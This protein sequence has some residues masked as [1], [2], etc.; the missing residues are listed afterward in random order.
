M[1]LGIRYYVDRFWGFATAENGDDGSSSSSS[2]SRIMNK[3]ILLIR[4]YIV[5]DF[6]DYKGNI[7]CPRIW[8]TSVFYWGKNGNVFRPDL[9]NKFINMLTDISWNIYFLLYISML[10]NN[11]AA[12]SGYRIPLI[13]SQI[14]LAT[15]SCFFFVFFW[16]D[17]IFASILYI[18][19]LN[20]IKK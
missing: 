11:V 15:A 4:W 20:P 2:W 19:A 7:L 8:C 5:W 9:W 18:L 13:L 17:F 1:K 14:Q 16:P 12:N 3:I 10:I 6:N